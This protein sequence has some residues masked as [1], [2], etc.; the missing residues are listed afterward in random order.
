MAKKPP[1]RPQGRPEHKPTEKTRALVEALSGFGATE[2]YISSEIKV[3]EKTLRKYYAAELAKGHEKANVQVA[4]ALFKNAIKGNVSAQIFWAKT[5]MGWKETQTHEHTGKDGEAIE[6]KVSADES[7]AAFVGAL[8][9]AATARAGG[10]DG[11]S[12]VA[13]K[14]KT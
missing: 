13:G 14:G 7:F 5:R 10:A 11:A 3:G 6:H 8:E 12:G 4:Q 2:P 1:V 9:G